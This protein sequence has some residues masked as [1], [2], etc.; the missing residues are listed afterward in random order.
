M[1]VI[2]L[3]GTKRHIFRWLHSAESFQSDVRVEDGKFTGHAKKLM[4]GVIFIF[5]TLLDYTSTKT[6]IKP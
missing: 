4:E 3:K 5:K 1:T 6:K 2:F